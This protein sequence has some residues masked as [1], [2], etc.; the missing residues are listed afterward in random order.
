MKPRTRILAITFAASF[1]FTVFADEPGFFAGI[2]V[3]G[4]TAHGRSS[5]KDGGG[6]PF[7]NT[8]GAGGKVDHVKFKDTTGIGGHIG[9]RFTDS[10]LSAFISYQHI[11][12]KLGW[13]ASYSLFP[14]AVSSFDA[15][16]TSNILLGNIAYDWRLTEL[17]SVRASLGLG[18]AY[19]ALS[20][21]TETDKQTGQFVSKVSNHREASPA[22]QFTA[23]LRHK[24]SP[25]IVLGLDALVS[26]TGGFETGDTR[27]GNLGITRINAYKIDDVWRA[28]VGASLTFNF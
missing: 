22:A 4:G 23:G 8:P 19:N 3:T 27:S 12:G 2:D 11:R 7:T 21:T 15:T 28:N 16:A 5:T 14:G 10:P 17:T 20:N 24:V 9:Y 1:P 25:N 13:D 26:Y 6:N 18:V